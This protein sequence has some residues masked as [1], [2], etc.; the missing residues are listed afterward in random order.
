VIAPGVGTGTAAVVVTSVDVIAI[1][2]DVVLRTGSS[3]GVTVTVWNGLSIEG[4][5]KPT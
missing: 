2:G 3:T 4:S 5:R 1:D